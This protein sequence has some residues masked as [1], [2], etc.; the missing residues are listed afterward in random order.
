T[1]K[2]IFKRETL[3]KEIAEAN[4]G[5]DAVHC[6]YTP[7]RFAHT[8]L[9]PYLTAFIGQNPQ[10]HTRIR[11]NRLLLETAYPHELAQSPGGVYPDQEIYTPSVEDQQHAFQEYSQ[12]AFRRMQLGQ[13]RPG[14][15]VKLVDGKIMVGGT[16]AVM[17]IN[18]LLAKTIFDRNPNHEFFIE[19]S[20]PL[21]WMYPYLTPH[22]VIMKLK[23]QPLASIPEDTLRRDH[24][25][26]KQYSRR[27][28]G[29]IIDSDTPVRDICAW[30]EKTSLRSDFSGF[31]GDRKF[32]HDID[33]Q[34]SFSK[35]RT[36]I[37]GIYAWRLSQGCPAELRPKSQP[38]FLA[39]VREA[40]FAFLQAF[41]FCPWSPEA[42]LRYANFL[43]QC[44]R[45][46]DALL[47]AETCLKFDPYDGQVS[48][49]ADN[50]RQ[51]KRQMQTSVPPRS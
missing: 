18:A 4:A 23:R 19:E 1:A 10:S 24:E 5:P 48:S 28:T 33:A 41:A 8:S 20:F 21:D 35:L 11:L 39:L 42:V 25:F 37:A 9:S 13:L 26:W 16:V 44:N 3:E 34:K 7:D 15:D 51:I 50:L 22:G 12:D 29:D 14:E 27:L 6:L 31:T 43:L 46:D 2:I 36:A 45:I 47:I 30:L 17:S 49:L 38:E 40:N 32:I